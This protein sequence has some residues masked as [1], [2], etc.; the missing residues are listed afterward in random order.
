MDFKWPFPET[1]ARRNLV[2]M[3]RLPRWSSGLDRSFVTSSLWLCDHENFPTLEL[4][5]RQL[6]RDQTSSQRSTRDCPTPT[7]AVSNCSTGSATNPENAAGPSLDNILNQ[8]QLNS[9]ERQRV[10]GQTNLWICNEIYRAIWLIS[11]RRFEGSFR[12]LSEARNQSQWNSPECHNVPSQTNVKFHRI[13]LN[14]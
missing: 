4:G 13:P 3:C 14:R 5:R 9:A 8:I 2:G 6:N 1:P 7:R 11:G 12:W 10:P